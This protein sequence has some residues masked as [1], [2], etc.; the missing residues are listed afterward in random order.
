ME[1]IK[2]LPV[3]RFVAFAVALAIIL[4]L[5]SVMLSFTA[6]AETADDTVSQ[7]GTLGNYD[8]IKFKAGQKIDFNTLYDQR[9]RYNSQYVIGAVFGYKNGKFVNFKNNNFSIRPQ[10]DS[11]R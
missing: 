1:K 6:S 5:S 10:S 2:N 7:L 8:C 11:E 9:N 4:G 3:M